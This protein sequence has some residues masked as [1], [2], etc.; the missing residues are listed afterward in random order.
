M[1]LCYPES[2]SQEDVCSEN[3]EGAGVIE[4]DSDLDLDLDEENKPIPLSRMAGG[5]LQVYFPKTGKLGYAEDFRYIFSGGLATK[6]RAVLVFATKRK[7]NVDPR[8]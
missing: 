2:L 8:P 7:N 5:D 3:A 4:V 6:T 1:R